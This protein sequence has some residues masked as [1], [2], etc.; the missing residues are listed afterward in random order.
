[1]AQDGDLAYLPDRMPS[2]Q[3]ERLLAAAFPQS[4]DKSQIAI[5]VERTGGALQPADVHVAGQL[6]DRFEALRDELP[7]VDIWS[8]KSEI[9]G[10]KLTSHVTPGRARLLWSCCG[11][12]TSSWLP[13]T[14][15]S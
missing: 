1:M 6:A 9:V 11:C 8:R 13:T 15:A 2:V 10:D 3:G 5:V 7:I 4:K 14:C 12:R